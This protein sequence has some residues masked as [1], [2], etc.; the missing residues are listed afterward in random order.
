VKNLNFLF[1]DERRGRRKEKIRKK[2]GNRLRSDL[3]PSSF[4]STLT[5]PLSTSFVLWKRGKGKRKRKK[6]GEEEG[7]RNYLTNPFGVDYDVP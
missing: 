5:F 1:L 2:E 7:R 6:G 3:R 4:F